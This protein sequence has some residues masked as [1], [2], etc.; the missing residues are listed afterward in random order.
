MIKKKK[1]PFLGIQ[2]LFDLVDVFLGNAI[3]NPHSFICLYIIGFAY[4][5]ALCTQ[6]STSVIEDF[7]NYESIFTAAHELGHR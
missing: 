5:G 4:V 3:E 6:A 2:F 7:G 1:K